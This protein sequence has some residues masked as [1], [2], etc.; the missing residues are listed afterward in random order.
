MLNPKVMPKVSDEPE[1]V[2][3]PPGMS[4]EE[5]KKAKLVFGDNVKFLVVRDELDEPEYHPVETGIGS[6]LN[7]SHHH[8]VAL[9][10]ANR[11][12]AAHEAQI[13]LQQ[14]TI[15]QTKILEKLAEKVE[16]IAGDKKKG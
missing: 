2:T 12:R 1:Y 11:A 14:S 9:E 13:T 4:D 16:D 10:K 5:Y 15:Q 3:R 8:K 7:P 6:A